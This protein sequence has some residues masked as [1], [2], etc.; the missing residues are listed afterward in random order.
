[1][2]IDRLNEALKKNKMSGNALCK[3]MNISN[4]LYTG[5]KTNKP[6]ADKL[7]DMADILNVSVDWLL[8]REDAMEPIETELMNNFRASD[9]DGK[10]TIIS[11]AELEARRSRKAKTLQ[12]ERAAPAEQPIQFADFANKAKKDQNDEQDKLKPFA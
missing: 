8:E 3:K 11:V 5:W 4:S 1:M 12:D 10:H 9:E 6:Q 7:K 2:F